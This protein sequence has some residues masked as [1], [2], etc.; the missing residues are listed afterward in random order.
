MRPSFLVALAAALA[1]C[2]AMI[3]P[4]APVADLAPAPTPDR[5]AELERIDAAMDE[6]MRAARIASEQGLVPAAAPRARPA[7]PPLPTR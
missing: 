2:V 4:A 7:P 1:A 3:D 5:A 6:A